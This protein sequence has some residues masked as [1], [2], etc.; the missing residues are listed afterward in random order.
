MVC[1]NRQCWSE[2]YTIYQDN[3]S[4]GTSTNLSYSVNGLTPSTTYEFKIKASDDANNLSNFSNAINV[5]TNASNQLQLASGN[6]E[7]ILAILLTMLLAVQVTITRHPQI[8][9]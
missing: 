2:N 4:I 6:I 5:T 3:S 9:N 8:H 7:N 1:L